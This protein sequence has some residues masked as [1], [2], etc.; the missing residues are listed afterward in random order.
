MI[1]GFQAA[2]ASVIA[3]YP[4]A[5]LSWIAAMEQTAVTRPRL[6]LHNKSLTNRDVD[7]L[8]TRQVGYDRLADSSVSLLSVSL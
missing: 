2:A 3:I 1:I 6:Y 8:P 5:E 7:H 4:G